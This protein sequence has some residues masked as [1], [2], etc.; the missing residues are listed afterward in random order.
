MAGFA[1][2]FSPATAIAA[3]ASAPRAEVRGVDDR[4]LRRL[5]QD[6]VGQAPSPISRLEARRR[7]GDAA[8]QAVALLRSEGYYDSTVTADIGD[9]DAPIPFIAV[10][11]GPLTRIAAPQIEWSGA[12][13]DAATQ[14]AAV[15]ALGLKPG[16][17]A[18]AGDVL[19]AEG[20]AISTL[21]NLG[22]ADAAA[23][24]REVVV[25]HADNTMRPLYRLSAGQA[26]RLGAARLET[27]GHTRPTW[28]ARL[29]PWKPGQAYRPA[30][31]AELE[32]RL[33][34]TA[35][36]DSVTVGLAPAAESIHG[37]R[38]VIVSLSERPKGSLELGASYS[39]TEGAGVDSRWA[40][41]NRLGRG[42]TLT[43]TLQF[44]QIDS[45]LQ[46]E[47][48]LPHWRR[49]RETLKL[50]AA[51]YR[52]RTAAY[53]LIGAGL[54]AD[55][56]H[57]Y[58]KTSFLTY[59][60]SFDETQTMEKEAANYVTGNRLRLLSSFGLLTAFTADHAN[61][62]LNPT[63]G[64]RLNGR[65]EPKMDFGDGSVTFVKV[66]GQASGYLPIFGA[67]TTV[68]AARVK[69]GTILGGTVPR[70]PAPDRFYAGG[71]G[72][73]RGFGYQAVGPRYPDNTP[74]GGLSLFETSFEIRQRLTRNWGVVAFVDA[75]SVGE[76][77]APNFRRPDIGAG[78]GVR[79]NLGF[80]P[81]RFDI[82]TPLTRRTGDAALQV[83]LSIGQSF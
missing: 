18:R 66:T 70:V 44:A 12:P 60:A 40:I 37:L 19:A 69:L 27:K 3:G 59:G 82:A 38:P 68:L 81:I 26:V 4:A 43:T 56:T 73:V 32:R 77:V 17:A 15:A 1:C 47:L 25:D 20:R 31:V 74:R 34:D 67:D 46:T 7:A 54:S 6:A 76:L 57:R 78:I 21:Q 42:D 11:L 58:G 64:F 61:D 50:T 14:S 75:G 55:L 63:S 24:T 41:Y 80:G 83:Y 65:V 30:L 72:S 45:R 35:A 49:A 22:Y 10:T 79:Y 71:G 51:V 13:P 9:G 23:G 33:I 2:G 52:D 8:E 16:Q 62:P 39:T 29:T 36:F 48:A 28:L 5:I 53:D